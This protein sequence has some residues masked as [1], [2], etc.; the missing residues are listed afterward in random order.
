ML[1]RVAKWKG[2]PE[3][4]WS[5]CGPC[6]GYFFDLLLKNSRYSCL[7]VIGKRIQNGTALWKMSKVQ[8]SLI[9]SFTL[10]ASLR[11]S[12]SSLWDEAGQGWTWKC[13][14]PLLF[15]FTW[16]ESL[17]VREMENVHCRPTCLVTH[18]VLIHL[19]I[20]AVTWTRNCRGCWRGWR[21]WSVAGRRAAAA[22]LWR[23]WTGTLSNLPR[24]VSTATWL[25]RSAFLCRCSLSEVTTP[26]G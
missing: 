21:V 4:F 3:G 14:A 6:L 12:V 23:R 9:N 17:L 5:A 2:L 25:S 18:F 10:A 1:V 22:S 20:T 13:Q 24:R 7:G 16:N 26:L 11:G 19:Q 8:N 15:R